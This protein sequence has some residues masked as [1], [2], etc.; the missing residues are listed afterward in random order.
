MD[1]TQEIIKDLTSKMDIITNQ[2]NVMFDFSGKFKHKNHLIIYSYLLGYCASKGNNMFNKNI[3]INSLEIFEKS[4]SRKTE[5]SNLIILLSLSINNHNEKENKNMKEE[6][7]NLNLKAEITE[8]MMSSNPYQAYKELFGET[9]LE[10]PLAKNTMLG[11]KKIINLNNIQKVTKN[12]NNININ[13]NNKNNI[14]NNMNININNI[15]NENNNIIRN[16]T[17]NNNNNNKLNE[18]KD[19]LNFKNIKR[20]ENN[21]NNNL[22]LENKK[23]NINIKNNYNFNT[24]NNKT[25][26]RINGE[27]NNKIQWDNYIIDKNI[28]N[29][30]YS[31]PKKH[32]QNAK[33]VQKISKN[34]IKCFICSE[35]YNVLD[36]HN[37]NKLNCKCIIHSKC[38]KK[39]I[40]NSIK[41]KKIPILCPKCKSE[42][43]SNYIYDCLNSIG[44]KKLINQYENIYFD[45]FI[46]NYEN[47]G[48]NIIY[49]N[50]PTPGCNKFIPCKNKDKK[51]E[52]PTC[53]K[54]YCLKCYKPWHNNKNCEDYYVQN[55]NDGF[56]KQLNQI[57][58]KV[59]GLY[60]QCP[61]CHTLM[62]KEKEGKTIKCVCGNNF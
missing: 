57:D 5:L 12:N 14:Y 30:A 8:T 61:K 47:N 58:N 37:Y 52:C 43:S 27:N 3:L 56:K 59:N 17:E 19:I 53:N 36:K 21:I 38:F 60:K 54:A 20:T 34:D 11:N 46:K 4:L 23:S 9:V 1:N 45:I 6:K 2:L 40:I 7:K 18:K 48:N 55:S 42:I 25:P 13:N 29:K 31:I 26:N 49:Y 16:N 22:I 51:L 24:V 10:K 15:K 62:L 41:N 28:T 44:D 39:Y 35:N 50:C 32:K 33:V